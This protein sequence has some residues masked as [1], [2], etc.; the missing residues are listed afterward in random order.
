MVISIT[1]N[2]FTHMAAINIICYDDTRNTY[3][4]AG[5]ILTDPII[6]QIR[7][8]AEDPSTTKTKIQL[9]TT[10]ADDRVVR[11]SLTVTGNRATIEGREHTVCYYS[12][13]PSKYPLKTVY[14]EAL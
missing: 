5:I 10:M 3:V 1:F 2:E 14:V 11:P 9:P 7:E 6:A 13:N 8:A 4:D 12:K